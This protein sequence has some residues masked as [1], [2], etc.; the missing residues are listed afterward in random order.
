MDLELDS[1]LEIFLNEKK[2]VL[3]PIALKQYKQILSEL[4]KFTGREL[5]TATKL[6]IVN[7][8]SHLYNKNLKKSSISTYQRII[9]SFY[10]YLYN[11]NLIPENPC[12]NLYNVKPEQKAPI[13]LTLEE[14]ELL[15]NAAKNPR[16]RLIFQ[17]LYATGLRVSELINIRYR[18][19]DF[20]NCTIKVFGKGSR[21][22]YVLARQE[23]LDEIKR[24]CEEN[25][26]SDM[27]KLFN[28]TARAI[29]LNIKRAATQAG[30][31]KEVTPHKLRHSFATHMLQ[32]G[33][34]IRAIQKLLGH[35]SLNTTQIYADYSIEDLK[36]IYNRTHPLKVKPS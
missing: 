10:G 23:L 33:A 5:K 12:R 11:N 24:Y 20:K 36:E 27:D 31:K 29:E 32:M 3:S 18:D 30:I 28:I 35:S 17:I 26:K 15:F 2:L 19:I 21:E 13:Y 1:A 34:D 8:L 7:F 25:K 4:R 9:K 22:R 14:V 16:D 6:D